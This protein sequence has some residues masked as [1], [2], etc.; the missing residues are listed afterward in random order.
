VERRTWLLASFGLLAEPF[1]VEAQQPKVYRIGMLFSVGSP[2]FRPESD[3]YDRAFAEGLR[4]HGYVV[5]QHVVIER[6][7]ARGQWDEL[8]RLAAELVRLNVDAIVVPGAATAQPAR[9]ATSTIPIVM[10]AVGDP[11]RA[12]LVANLARPGGNITGLSPDYA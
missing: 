3:P 10:V 4:E 5:G 9:Q 12:G 7:S 6:R 2:E 1:A 11:V 8:P